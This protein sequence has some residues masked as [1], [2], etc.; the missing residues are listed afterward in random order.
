MPERSSCTI[1]PGSASTSGLTSCACSSV[2]TSSAV[3]ASSGPKSSVCRHV[4]SVSRPKTVMNH[5]IPAAGIRPVRPVPRIRSEAR[6]ETDWKNAWSIKSQ[7]ARI[8]G[9]RSCQAASDSRTRVISSPKRRSAVRG[10]TESPSIEARMSSRTSQLS[11][12][13]SSSR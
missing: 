11:R 5:G 1:F 6:S 10:V 7:S 8:W 12:G 9:T 13:S 4:I 2:S 3:R